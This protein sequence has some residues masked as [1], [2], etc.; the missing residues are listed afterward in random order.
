[1][2]AA[3]L[4]WLVGEYGARFILARK[5]DLNRKPKDQKTDFDL[6]PYKLIDEN[7]RYSLYEVPGCASTV[8]SA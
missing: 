4:E 3:S 5:E 8:R 7:D 1:V 2:N 6:S